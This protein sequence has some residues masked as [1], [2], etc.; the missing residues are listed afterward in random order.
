MRNKPAGEDNLAKGENVLY[1]QLHTA[2]LSL[3]EMEVVRLGN[4]QKCG[5]GQ[6]EVMPKRDTPQES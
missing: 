5:T 4:E 1:L 6:A 3:H 2:R